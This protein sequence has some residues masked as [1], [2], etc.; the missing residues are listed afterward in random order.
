MRLWKL[1]LL[2]EFKYFSADQFSSFD[3]WVY[4]VDDILFTVYRIDSAGIHINKIKRHELCNFSHCY[5]IVICAVP[6]FIYHGCIGR[7]SDCSTTVDVTHEYDSC[8]RS[9]ILY[10][11]Y[12]VCYC[13]DK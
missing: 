13:T 2:K 4:F 12:K 3:I 6:I 10:F 5:C 1:H 7:F 8:I 9:L 11:F